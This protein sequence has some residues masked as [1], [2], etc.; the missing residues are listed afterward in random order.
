MPVKVNVLYSAE[1]D[2]GHGIT[3]MVF[4]SSDAWCY[5]SR[6]IVYCARGRLGKPT[7]ALHLRLTGLL[8]EGELTVNHQ[9]VEET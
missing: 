9:G 6:S 7:T 3:I 4:I 5:Q 2:L 1:A 8:A